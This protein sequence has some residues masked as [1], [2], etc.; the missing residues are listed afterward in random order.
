MFSKHIAKY[1]KISLAVILTIVFT[2]ALITGC[3][4]CDCLDDVA[5]NEQ[6]EMDLQTSEQINEHAHEQ[7][8]GQ[9]MY[10]LI[11]NNPEVTGSMEISF[12]SHDFFLEATAEQLR[13]ALPTLDFDMLGTVS[14]NSDGTFVNVNARVPDPNP[15]VFGAR[16]SIWVGE[17]FRITS[18]FI[19]DDD[20][21]P[22]Y[23]Y[24]YEIPVIALMVDEGWGG[25]LFFRASFEIDGVQFH[26][27][28]SKEDSDAGQMLLT[29]IVNNL[30]IG[31]TDGLVVFD[32]PIIPELRSESITYEEALNDADFGGFVP[33]YV[34]DGFIN[35]S[36]AHRWVQGHIDVNTMFLE[37]Q[38]SFDYDYLYEIYAEWVE[39]RTYDVF[40]FDDI[41]WGW[42]SV[43]WTVTDIDER[44][45]ERIVSADDYR[46]FDW[47][48]YPQSEWQDDDWNLPRRDIPWEYFATMHDP[49]FRADEITL[50]IV[51]IREEMRY[52]PIHGADGAISE[53]PA[54]ILF[55]LLR[56][57]I[58]FGV[59][60]DDGVLI[61]ISAE[62]MTY[63]QIW[64]MLT[65]IGENTVLIRGYR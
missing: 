19:F 58:M 63:E 51:R 9:T 49:I 52:I 42:P 41:F 28:L 59:L 56:N 26:I 29:E 46:L 23:S 47:S 55:P 17:D 33:T 18:E 5:T 20:F 32:N 40:A 25:E 43:R 24:V 54:D 61:N 62:G 60:F 38:S 2:V 37:W 16:I 14:Y 65:S 27:R 34:P 10:P 53:N 3:S 35:Q 50:D 15:Y 30:I 11:F 57:Y 31:G 45:F 22:E 12:E 39:A 13:I 64:E 21:V 4:A 48:L 8:N 1:T 44:D 7:V 6:P 36:G